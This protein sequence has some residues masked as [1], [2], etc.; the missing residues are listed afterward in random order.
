M[1]SRAMQSCGALSLLV[2]SWVKS[3]LKATPKICLCVPSGPK[4]PNPAAA[5]RRC[6]SIIPFS[7]CWTPLSTA[8]T[9]RSSALHHR[10]PSRSAVLQISISFLL[11]FKLHRVSWVESV[12]W[13]PSHFLNT[14]A[15]STK[16]VKGLSA[17]PWRNPGLTSSSWLSLCVR[18]IFAFVFQAAL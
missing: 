5:V 7:S 17:H 6:Y 8:C 11:L 9:S 4:K 3:F 10:V 13:M 15:S 14:S 16:S 2:A 1:S 18:D 12:F